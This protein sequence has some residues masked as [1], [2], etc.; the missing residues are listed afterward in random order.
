L[1]L[2]KYP[3]DKRP[4]ELNLKLIFSI[5]NNQILSVV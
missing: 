4:I 2:S 3:I 5:W 1:Q